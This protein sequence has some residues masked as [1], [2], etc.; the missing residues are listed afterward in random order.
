M[1]NRYFSDAV[2]LILDQGGTVDKFV[3]DAMM[4]LF[5]AP[6]R[7]R[8]HALRGAR[9]ALAMQEAM[10]EAVVRNPDLP[11]FRI[12]LNTGSALVGNIGTAQIRN[13]TAIGDAV[14]VAARLQE[15]AQPGEVVV[16]PGTYEC[17]R[18]LAVFRPL[19]PVPVRGKDEPVAAYV[20]ERL[21]E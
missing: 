3:G 1:L 13:F 6:V 5:N 4:A 21:N 9:A 15:A 19:G 11:C 20:L 7:Q 14:N 10:H 16:G 18:Q 2:P 8:D 17:L 12:G